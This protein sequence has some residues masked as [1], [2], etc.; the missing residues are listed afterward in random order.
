MFSGR[1][2]VLFLRDKQ[3]RLYLLFCKFDQ[4]GK[5]REERAALNNILKTNKPKKYTY[6]IRYQE[7]RKTSGKSQRYT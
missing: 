1:R 7:K 2:S 4:G 5:E 6:A 3:K